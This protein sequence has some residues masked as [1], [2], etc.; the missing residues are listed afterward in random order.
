MD[1]LEKDVAKNIYDCFYPTI[2]YFDSKLMV[3]SDTRI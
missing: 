1:M 2:L 3:L